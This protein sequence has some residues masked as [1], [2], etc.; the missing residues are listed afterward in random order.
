M[1]IAINVVIHTSMVVPHPSRRATGLGGANVTDATGSPRHAAAIAQMGDGGIARSVPYWAVGSGPHGAHPGKERIT[2]MTFA[3]SRRSLAATALAA[4]L[5]LPV[6]AS[7]AGSGPGGNGGGHHGSTS[8]G[9]GSSI[10]AHK[11]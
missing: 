11:A 8:G 9:H 2:Q 1:A 4:S 10:R 7:A 6:A 5:V 3:C